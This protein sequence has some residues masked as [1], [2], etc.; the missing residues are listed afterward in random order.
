[1]KRFTFSAPITLRA[2]SGKQ[3][4]FRILAYS[5]GPLNVDGFD[6]PVIVDLQGLE[7]SA[8]QIVLNHEATTDATLGQVDDLQNDGR[9][10]TLAGPITGTSPRVQDV[11]SAADAGHQWQAS[12]GAEVT[13][14]QRIPEGQSVQ[15]NGRTF[16]GPVIVARRSVL[17]ETSVLPIGAD[18]T[19]SVDL[20]AKAATR[21]GQQM[22]FETWLKD[23]GIDS[24][25][26]TE[27]GRA[28]LMKAFEEQATADTP[29]VAA[30]AILD[31]RAARAADHRRIAQ[32]EA[33]C[34]RH[35]MIAAKAI[36]AGWSVVETE[37][38]VLKASQGR[39]TATN[40]H[41]SNHTAQPTT[42]VLSASL[43][44]RA[45]GEKLALKAYGE[46]TVE[47][48]R[49]AK[50][51]NL[52]DLA[53]QSLRAVGRS[54][55]EFGGREQMIRAA[56]STAS[57]P[58]I[59]ADTVGRTLE[60]AYSETTSDWKKFCHIASAEDFRTQTGIRPAAIA[61]LDQYADGGKIKH[62]VLKEEATYSWNVDTFAKM[63]A[64]TRKTIINDDLGFI[65]QLSPM[66]GTA[67]GRSLL[68][69][70]WQTIMNGQ[71]A[72]HFSTANGNLVTG[73]SLSV[74]SL[75]IAVR[76]MKEQTDSQ[77]YN[78][79][80]APVALVVSPAWELTARNML[81]SP[82]L[83][84]T[85][86]ETTGLPSGNPVQNIVKDLIVEPRLSNARFTG[87][88]DDSFYLFAGPNARPVTVG[89]LQQ[90]QSPTIEINDA[91]FDELGIQMRVVFDYG[92]AMGDPVAGYKG[93]GA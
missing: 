28:V 12:I 6:L 25:T 67:A 15:V 45:G 53:G 70:I 1:M 68:D 31:L 47:A 13:A 50:I 78:I 43:L 63:L 73:T 11:L 41:G 16:S 81:A 59:L 34:T 79:G 66:L 9:S 8:V 58:N 42:A 49:H 5:G 84:G 87:N 55:D 37:N 3:R 82:Q 48:A 89:F 93:A 51:T 90:Q 57:L 30:G 54:P 74:G 20:A 39:T 17:R 33:I 26:L 21:Q 80:V 18:A 10:L 61:N 46:Q 27:A 38:A 4:R 2:A 92:C 35:P 60:D 71:T 76:T 52:V 32:I 86:A 65:S 91:P 77:G 88:N 83:F 24:A 69:L 56:F 75:A 40:F 22:D 44:L 64:V 29:A 7:A 19:T 85:T 72:N 62:G 14:Q 23:M 36:E